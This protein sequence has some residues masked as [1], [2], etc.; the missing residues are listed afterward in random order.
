MELHPLDD[1]LQQV[2]RYAA[3]KAQVCSPEAEPCAFVD[4]LPDVK[5]FIDYVLEKTPYL[6]YDYFTGT[7]RADVYRKLGNKHMHEEIAAFREAKAD[8]DKLVQLF[9][10]YFPASEVHRPCDRTEQAREYL[11]AYLETHPAS[12][13]SSQELAELV[14]HLAEILNYPS[15]DDGVKPNR[16][17]HQLGYHTDRC[18]HKKENP[19]YQ[20]FKI[21]V[22]E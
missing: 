7:F 18:S 5:A 19:G 4:E 22:P 12:C 15:G 14:D 13:L 10:R 11:N 17:L 9:Q 21:V 16:I 3:K 8:P 20:N 1:M 6:R 2:R